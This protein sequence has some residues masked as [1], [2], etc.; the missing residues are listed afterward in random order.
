MHFAKA[1]RSVVVPLVAVCFVAL[2][3]F[4]LGYKNAAWAVSFVGTVMVM[5]LIILYVV[6]LDSRTRW[7]GLNWRQRL[8]KF[9]WFER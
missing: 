9:V 2:L 7:P 5:F 4:A 8:T 6:L 3:L 1:C